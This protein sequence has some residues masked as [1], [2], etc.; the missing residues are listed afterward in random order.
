VLPVNINSMNITELQYSAD[1][2]PMRATVAVQLTVI[3]GKSIPYLYSKAM[4]EAM[5]VL[6]LA[7]LADIANVVIPG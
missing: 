1:L 7:N 5:S 3:E 6:N 2:N 4:Q